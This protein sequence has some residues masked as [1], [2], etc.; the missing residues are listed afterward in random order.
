MWAHLFLFLQLGSKEVFL[1]GA[2]SMFQNFCWWAAPFFKK[3]KKL[4][5]HPRSWSHTC[6]TIRDLWWRSHQKIWNRP[7][8]GT[9]FKNKGEFSQKYLRLC[10]LLAIFCPILPNTMVHFYIF[11]CNWAVREKGSRQYFRIAGLM[12]SVHSCRITL[13][14]LRVHGNTVTWLDSCTTFFTLVRNS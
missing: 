7:K 3:K 11:A 9:C 2:Y 4:W 13:V 6:I 14:R 12:S 5:A 10:W 8:L 1:L